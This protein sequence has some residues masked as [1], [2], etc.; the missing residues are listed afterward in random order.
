MDFKFHFKNAS[1]V[2]FDF[3]IANICVML[4]L[5]LS[6]IYDNRFLNYNYLLYEFE[7]IKF[8]SIAFFGVFIF[9]LLKFYF[10]HM[11]TIIFGAVFIS[12][13]FLMYSSFLTDNS[14]V[15][16]IIFLTLLLI[17]SFVIV[18]FL[19]NRDDNMAILNY[20]IH[21]VF[22]IFISLFSCL[23]IYV[24]FYLIIEGIIDLLALDIHI[25]IRISKFYTYMAVVIFSIIGLNIFLNYVVKLKTESIKEI[26]K[27]ANMLYKFIFLSFSILMSIL[28]I[29]YLAKVIITW[30][31]PNGEIVTYGLIYS[32]IILITNIFLIS[33]NIYE[34]L[35]KMLW[36][37]IFICSI[38]MLISIIIRINQYGLTDNRVISFISIVWFMGVSIYFFIK[39]S[40]KIFYIFYSCVI[41][42]SITFL[43]KSFIVYTFQSKRLSDLIEYNRPISENTDVEIRIEITKKLDYLINNYDNNFLD[44]NKLFKEN[45][46]PCYAEANRYLST[47]CFTEK[48]GFEPI[49]FND[50]YASKYTTFESEFG[51]FAGLNTKGYDYISELIEFGNFFNENSF[52]IKIDRTELIFIDSNQKVFLRLDMKNIIENI[53]KLATKKGSYNDNIPLEKMI[54]NIENNDIKC[55]LYISRIDITN[56]NEINS[57]S[58]KILIKF[59]R[60][61]LN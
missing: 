55:K 38:M 12:I 61:F 18:N 51:Q 22:A 7:L 40:P 30:D 21:I 45:F 34:K 35:S 8:I 3:I 29:I 17:L 10:S 60:N 13:Y 9:T 44:K 5:I 23:I 26:S 15:T 4:F 43:I 24:G 28:I 36:I 19:K 37:G 20:L 46:S 49:Y 50:V 54:F 16:Q 56:E 59:K 58:G 2:F 27:I 53:N 42:F 11:K 39:N 52:S 25:D 47:G 1:K 6:F 14:F 31:I 41:I 32:V 48:L 33:H 57:M